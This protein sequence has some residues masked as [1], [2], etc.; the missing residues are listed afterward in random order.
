MSLRECTGGYKLHK[1]QMDDIKLVAKNEKELKTLIQEEKIYSEN[2]VMELSIEKCTLLII[3]SG[4]QQMTEV[5]ELPNR[6]E[7]RKLTNTWEY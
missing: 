6:S 2:I 7:K 1:S 4:K 3:K 5:T